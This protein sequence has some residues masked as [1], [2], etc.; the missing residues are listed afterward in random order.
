[1]LKSRNRLTTIPLAKQLPIDTQYWYNRLYRFIL[2]AAVLNFHLLF[3]DKLER[4]RDC[5][6]LTSALVQ[7]IHIPRGFAFISNPLCHRL[8]T[9]ECILSYAWESEWVRCAHTHA[10]NVCFKYLIIVSRGWCHSA[11]RL[12]GGMSSDYLS[13]AAQK[14]KRLQPLPTFLWLALAH[15][16]NYISLWLSIHIPLNPLSFMDFIF[17]HLPLPIF[18]VSILVIPSTSS[19]AVFKA[20]FIPLYSSRHARDH[21]Q[22]SR[23]SFCA[24]NSTCEI[25][26]SPHPHT[27]ACVCVC[28]L[29]LY[30]QNDFDHC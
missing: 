20:G 11:G 29:E 19:L 28:I 26:T 23:W 6:K 21:L 16:S 14:K 22:Q 4:K 25:H 10:V 18:N 17:P 30:L 1:M 2:I 9:S 5:L 27:C 8:L 13:C 12:Q 3:L 24:D 7:R 15:P